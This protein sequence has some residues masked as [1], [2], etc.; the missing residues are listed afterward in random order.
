MSFF[1]T[2][3]MAYIWKLWHQ[4]VL[5]CSSH[6][7]SILALHF[8][9]QQ[10][11]AAAISCGTG[12]SILCPRKC[13]P[14][15]PPWTSWLQKQAHPCKQ[16]Q[17]KSFSLLS[18][19]FTGGARSV[20][21]ASFNSTVHLMITPYLFGISW[22]LLL[23]QGIHLVP[24]SRSWFQSLKNNKNQ[25]TNKKTTQTSLTFITFSLLFLLHLYPIMCFWYYYQAKLGLVGC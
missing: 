18:C 12:C 22:A 7:V 17:N 2:Q 8:G 11:V 20:A 24:T 25:K 19:S 9:Q 23:V 5:L 13:A 14:H 16:G 1:P 6:S 4:R 10:V 15:S 3:R 21:Q